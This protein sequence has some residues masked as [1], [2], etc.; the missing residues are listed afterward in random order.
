MPHRFMVCMPLVGILLSSAALPAGDWPEFRG[1]GQQG[2]S[3][4]VNLP[5]TWSETEN[6][7]WKTDLPGL[8]WSSPSIANGQ[9]WL[10]S[11]VKSDPSQ[12]A[13]DLVAI[14]LDPKSGAVLKTVEIF[15]KD[16][17]GSIHSKNSHAS[18]TPVIQGDKVYVHFGRH[19]TACLNTNG[20]ILWKTEL[21]YNHRHGPGGSPIL[22]QDLL[23]IACDGTD[24]QYMVA[25]DKN[26][27][28]EAWK[29]PRVEGRMAY[30]TPTM[31]VFNGQPQV[32]TSGG[33]FI[34]TYAPATGKELW[35]FRYPGGFSNVPRPV[36]AQGIAFASSGYNETFLYGVKL[37]GEGD[38]TETH[39]AWKTNKAVPRNASPIIVGDDLYLISDNGVATCLDVKTG[40]QHWQKRI[41][42]DFSSSPLFADGKLYI[43][44]ENGLTTVLKPGHEYEVLAENQLPGRIFASPVPHD[45]AIFLR[46][47][48]ALYRIE[49][50]K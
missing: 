12:P 14:C 24:I 5:L 23:I 9:L 1:S 13:V 37:G 27:G 30:S 42:G 11:A 31:T 28:K 15:H 19:G 44:N 6:I 25:L 33:E 29:T 10:T 32:V 3:D 50:P 39:L 48:A 36:V 2:V 21:E 45:G 8:G 40:E 41:G 20:D 43:V 34:S 22:F 38:V 49:N 17:P 47:E 26:T 35:R 7:A 46:T 4:E 16:D 18:P